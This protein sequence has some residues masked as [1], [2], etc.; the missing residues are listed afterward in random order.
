MINNQILN[1]KH[2]KV[3]VTYQS[4]TLRV[5]MGFAKGKWLN[6]TCKMQG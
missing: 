1:S 2:M 5:Y 3:F 6:E 4:V